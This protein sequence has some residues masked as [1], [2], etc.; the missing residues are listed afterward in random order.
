M[1]K[2]IVSSGYKASKNVLNGLSEGLDDIIERSL[3]EISAKIGADA[4]SEL[5]NKQHVIT[6]RTLGSKRIV[7]EKGSR[8]ISYGGGAYYIEHGRGLVLPVNAKV[9]RWI[10]KHT[11]EVVYAK[12][13][14]PTDPDPFL[15]PSVNRNKKKF[16]DII[17]REI[18]NKIKQKKK[19]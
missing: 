7:R 15:E 3:D 17:A 4:D 18:S 2:S 12:E 14:G 13:S 5:Q 1:T 19:E 11:G 9:L 10:D 6:G 8:T 16:S